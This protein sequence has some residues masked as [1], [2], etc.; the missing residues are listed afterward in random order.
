MAEMLEKHRLILNENRLVLVRQLEISSEF[1]AVLI[2]DDII[3]SVMAEMIKFEKTAHDK[4]AKFLDTLHKRGPKAFERFILSL[5]ETKQYDL[6][7][8]LDKDSC[9]K[10]KQEIDSR[11]RELNEMNSNH[12][13]AYNG[14][15]SDNAAIS[16]GW[17]NSA[18]T[19]V[20]NI[21]LGLADSQSNRHQEAVYA[22]A[23]QDLQLNE[24]CIESANN[25]IQVGLF[26]ILCLS[27]YVSFDSI[28]LCPTTIISLC[29]C[30]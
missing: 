5:V 23:S 10:F 6:A 24:L 4:A 27:L 17:D 28:S 18:D 11:R 30:L 8:L 14:H 3:T 16:N 9:W 12:A 2:R 26:I 25:H 13:S 20:S 1:F 29:S 21:T 7:A 22:E 19:S 15:Y